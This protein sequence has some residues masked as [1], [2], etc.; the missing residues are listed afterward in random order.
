M[1]PRKQ[2]T[3]EELGIDPAR[4]GKIIRIVVGTMVLLLIL[5]M[6]LM[7][8]VLFFDSA[9]HEE[10][11]PEQPF[12]EFSCLRHEPHAPHREAAI[13]YAPLHFAENDCRVEQVRPA[14]GSDGLAGVP[15]Q[16]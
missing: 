5:G 14:Y 13:D 12:M 9:T 15:W 6:M 16:G 10:P 1:S 2:Y 7:F 3:N 11:Q 4:E 8:A